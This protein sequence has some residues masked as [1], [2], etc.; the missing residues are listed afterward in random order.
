[1]AC[2]IGNPARWNGIVAGFPDPIVRNGFIEVWDRQGMGVEFNGEVARVYLLET[3][4]NLSIDTRV[5]SAEKPRKSPVQLT[6]AANSVASHHGGV[7]ESFG[8]GAKG[9]AKDLDERSPSMSLSAIHAALATHA[10]AFSVAAAMA[11]AIAGGAIS[12]SPASANHESANCAVGGNLD[13]GGTASV[14]CAFG[15]IAGTSVAGTVDVSDPAM[16]VA[17]N[18]GGAYGYPGVNAAAAIDLGDPS[19]VLA[20]GSGGSFPYPAANIAGSYP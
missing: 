14:G 16:T 17:G 3:D 8:A 13:D 5:A 7:P 2:W 18:Y 6:G 1:M 9:F 19:I 15:G 4:R 10:R 12:G 20:G 11:I